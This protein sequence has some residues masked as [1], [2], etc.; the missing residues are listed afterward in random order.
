M[1]EQKNNFET[2]SQIIQGDL[3]ESKAEVIAHCVS[4][5]FKMGAGIALEFRKRFGCLKELK[6]QKKEIGE[7]AILQ[8]KERHIAYM[9]TKEMYY[10]KPT[11][12]TVEKCLIYLREYLIK[13]NLKSLAMPRIGCG[14]DK[15]AWKDVYEIIDKVFCNTNITV[16]IYVL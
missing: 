4:K 7:C 14:L 12:Q 15:L 6:N 1:S 9:I 3:F 2:T 11:L 8:I 10:Q 16:Q 5:C 13:N